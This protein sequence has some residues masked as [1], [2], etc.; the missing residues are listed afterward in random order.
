MMHLIF[1]IQNDTI[2][3]FKIHQ[4]ENEIN[5][6]NKL[7]TIK[8]NDANMKKL[9]ENAKLSNLIKNNMIVNNTYDANNNIDDNIDDNINYNV[10]YNIDD[11][12]YNDTNDLSDKN[13]RLTSPKICFVTFENRKEEYINMHNENVKKY[14][15]KY[16]YEYVLRE[17]ND[18][19]ISPYWYKVFLVRELLDTN[20]YEYVFWMDSDTIINNF[21]IDIGKDILN[22]YDSDIFVA[23]DN[24]KYDIVNA[25][26]FV[27]KNSPIGK[28]FI[29]HWISLYNPSLCEKKEGGLKGIWALSCYEQGQLNKLLIEQYGKNTTMLEGHIF[30]NKDICFKN[31]FIMH[32]YGA[33]KYKRR[34]CFSYASEIN[35]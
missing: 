33:N 22:K 28:S 11:N 25:G 29:N 23:S 13:L 32:Y 35:K 31:V 4:E 21:D 10:N 3:T 16:G 24:T 9:Y 19:N 26:L 6:I 12:M 17:Q 27:V 2:E 14:C 18:T 34:N 20:K 8:E 30:Q 15:E 7:T 1:D 5:E